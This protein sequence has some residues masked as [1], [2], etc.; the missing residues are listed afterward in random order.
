M[1]QREP[2]PWTGDR[3]SVDTNCPL[4]WQTEWIYQRDALVRGSRVLKRS[5]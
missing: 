3:I 2:A 5:A 4:S 1:L